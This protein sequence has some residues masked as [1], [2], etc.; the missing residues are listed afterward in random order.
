MII[1][2]PLFTQCNVWISLLAEIEDDVAGSS[3][4]RRGV[5][6][7]GGARGRVHNV[8]ES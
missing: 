2:T 8:N 5:G 7:R 1:I 6:G 4:S 3:T